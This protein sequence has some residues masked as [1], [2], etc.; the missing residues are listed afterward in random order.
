MTN[1]DITYKLK[2]YADSIEEKIDIYTDTLR[3]ESLFET[4]SLEGP[5]LIL[6]LQV[7]K[8]YEIFPEIR[9]D[10]YKTHA[11]LDKERK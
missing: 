5:A 10:G 3:R 11:E 8:F 9:P 4:F 6:R 1:E 2:Q 7:D